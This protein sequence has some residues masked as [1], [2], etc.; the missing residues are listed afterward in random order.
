MLGTAVRLT[1]AEAAETTRIPVDA[2]AGHY[3]AVAYF[4]VLCYP[5]TDPRSHQLRNQFTTGLLEYIRGIIK[6][7]TGFKRITRSRIESSENSWLRQPRSMKNEQVFATCN[8]AESILRERRL[9]CAW[10]ASQLAMVDISEE[11]RR[12]QSRLQIRLAGPQRLS[13]LI[14][15]A[16]H[17]LGLAESRTM[18]RYWGE[19]LPVLHLA[20]EFHFAR[21]EQ[22]PGD[23]PQLA[24]RCT[25]DHQ[26]WLARAVDRAEL[27][28][29]DLSH[30][31]SFDPVKRICLLPE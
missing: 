4:A 16:T 5:G 13:G 24:V 18:W 3:G 23:R 27:R 1:A 6:Y 19:T 7:R 12:K 11:L 31:T 2:Q 20:L 14:E 10:I 9:P 28:A 26:L 15:A 25:R 8:R 30:Y 21:P 22:Q 17:R 29:L